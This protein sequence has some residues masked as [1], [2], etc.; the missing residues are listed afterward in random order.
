MTARSTLVAGLAAAAVAAAAL[1]V[2]LTHSSSDRAAGSQG[3]QA[4]PA[5]AAPPADVGVRRTKLGPILVDRRGH[6]LYLF[7]EDRSGRSHCFGAC[8]RVWPPLLASGRKPVAGDGVA[9]GKLA[10]TRRRDQTL[11]V[12]YN[13]HPLYGMT[14][15][16]RPGQMVGQG[17]LG[18][19]FVVSPAGRQIGKGH[20]G[21]Y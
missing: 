5:A 2:V 13:G 19:W 11:Q 16:K 17:F 4:A 20:G 6:T 15:D 3:T 12:V 1:V 10:T 8:A 14:A 18:T 9:A 21:G 7:R